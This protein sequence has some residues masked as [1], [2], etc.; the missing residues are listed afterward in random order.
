MPSEDRHITD[1]REAI[2]KVSGVTPVI[3][4]LL[5]NK[6]G[7]LTSGVA[8]KMMFM[9]MLAKTTRKQFTYGQGI[10]EVCRMVLGLLDKCGVYPTEASEREVEVVFP[11]PMPEDTMD[12]LKAAQ[13]KRELGVPQEEV[14]R[15][16]GYE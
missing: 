5:K 12:R 15:E 11:N 3:A 7:N 13:I 14:M 4:G 2:D 6:I 16:L 9:G 1:I 8:I 10:G